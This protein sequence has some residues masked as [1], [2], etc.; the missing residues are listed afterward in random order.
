MRALAASTVDVG[1]AVDGG[2]GPE[3]IF[4]PAAPLLY[5]VGGFVLLYSFSVEKLALINVYKRPRSLD[6]TAA[7]RSTSAMT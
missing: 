5:F 3:R 7:E 6:E 4:A 2:A 1:G